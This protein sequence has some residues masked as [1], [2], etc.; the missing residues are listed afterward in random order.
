MKDWINLFPKKWD[1]LPPWFAPLIVF[2][3]I[4]S[5]LIRD[6]AWN[7]S[8]IE[9]LFYGFM[10]VAILLFAAEYIGR[11]LTNTL[12]DFKY[13][14]HR[15]TVY[16]LNLILDRLHS[17]FFLTIIVHSVL[18]KRLKQIILLASLISLLTFAE[19]PIWLPTIAAGLLCLDLI[20]VAYRKHLRRYGNNALEIEEAV[21]YII[22][23]QRSGSGPR[24]G[25]RFPE[26]HP[27]TKTSSTE[28]LGHASPTPQPLR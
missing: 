11:F 7:I 24:G 19:L 17:R 10:S 14:I 4:L 5:L 3:L 27:R 12:A 1:D 22:A 20:C 21:R 18:K 13:Q 8:G 15:K 9:S 26:P 2:G 25:K 23:A 6:T 28:I 16:I